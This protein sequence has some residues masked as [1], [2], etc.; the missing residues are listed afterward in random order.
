[1][2]D[3]KLIAMYTTVFR[4]R[5]IVVIS[6]LTALLVFILCVTGYAWMALLLPTGI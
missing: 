3:L 4:A 1:M 6:G 2:V 5:A